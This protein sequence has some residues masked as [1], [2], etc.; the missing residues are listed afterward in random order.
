MTFVFVCILFC[1]YV[2]QDYVKGYVR[3]GLAY[4]A[5]GDAGE[6]D[7]G[8]L[9]KAERMFAAALEREPDNKTAKKGWKEVG[10]SL[11]LH[12]DGDE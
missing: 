11:Q 10:V 4:L 6:G 2:G 12:D 7:V 5:L 8:A 1:V 3:G 9:R